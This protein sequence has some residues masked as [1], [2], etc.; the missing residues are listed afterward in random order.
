MT[1]PKAITETI[2]ALR[3]ERGPLAARLD[4]IDLA[5]EN[6]SRVYGI[7]GRPQALPLQE[8]RKRPRRLTLAPDGEK[9]GRSAEANARRDQIVAA[10]E[11]A[12]H[13]LTIKELRK[14]TPKMEDKD[15]SNS[16]SVLR[17]QGKIKRAG[18]A[19]VVARAA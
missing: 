3:A 4:A 8:R 12:A 18:N 14:A 13:G 6:L 19:W 7:A 5:I 10:L 11:R 15:R 2:A 1:T 17:V 16:L 9:A